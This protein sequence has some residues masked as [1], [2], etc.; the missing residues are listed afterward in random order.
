VALAW[1]QS[2]TCRTAGFNTVP[3]G[4][5][6]PATL[7]LMIVLM[8]IGASPGSTGGGVKTIPVAITFLTLRAVLRGRERVE[9]YR[10]TLPESQVYRALLIVAVG[11]AI[12]TLLTLALVAFEDKPEKFQDHLFEVTS[13]LA[14][15]GLSTGVTP[16]LSPAGKVVIVLAMFIGRVGALTLLLALAG[17]HA[18]ENYRYPDEQVA[19][20]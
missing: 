16:E 3:I 12:Q 15:V 2:V 4:Q 19:L 20:S 14:T 8:F 9:V 10:R 1:F 18:P 13:A 5:L 11:A 17:G 6:T 7:F